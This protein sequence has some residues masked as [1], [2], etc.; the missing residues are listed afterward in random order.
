[1]ALVLK[2]GLG[3]PLKSLLYSENKNYLHTKSVRRTQY[4]KLQRSWKWRYMD[5]ETKIDL[6]RLPLEII[7]PWSVFHMHPSLEH[8]THLIPSIINTHWEISSAFPLYFIIFC[9]AFCL[10]LCEMHCHTKVMQLVY[11][12]F[13]LHLPLQ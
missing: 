11:F 2:G 5:N 12:F 1:M 13:S 6:G 3:Y 10:L 9:L 4:K 7:T 8:S